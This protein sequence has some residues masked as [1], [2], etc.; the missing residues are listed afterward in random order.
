MTPATRDHRRSGHRALSVIHPT[1]ASRAVPFSFYDLGKLLASFGGVE[2]TRAALEAFRERAR[3]AGVGELHLNAVAW[4]RPILPRE[5]TPAYLPKLVNDLGLDSTTSYVWVHHV[6]LP[7]LET[8]YNWARDRYLEA[9]PT[10]SPIPCPYCP[11]HA[12]LG[13]TLF[14]ASERFAR[15]TSLE[16]HQRQHVSAFQGGAVARLRAGKE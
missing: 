15:Y 5:Q 14:A 2:E 6:G 4:G 10:T 11:N 13:T 12:R 9:S 1:G 7:E 16:Y 8:D 3:T